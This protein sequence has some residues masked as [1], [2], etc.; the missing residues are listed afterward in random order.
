MAPTCTPRNPAQETA[1]SVQFSPGMRFIVFDFG[2]YQPHQHTRLS[3]Y[4]SMPADSTGPMSIPTHAYQQAVP[5]RAARTMPAR[6]VRS[7][8]PPLIPAPAP[9]GAHHSM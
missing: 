4:R 3:A 2:V 1:I 7:L 9:G 8:S 6:S 5:A